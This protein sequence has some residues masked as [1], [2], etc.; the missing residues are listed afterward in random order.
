MI[1]NN[2]NKNMLKMKRLHAKN[3]RDATQCNVSTN[4]SQ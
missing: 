1:V 3:S 2:G 4:G